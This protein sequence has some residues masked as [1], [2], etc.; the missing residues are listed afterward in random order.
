LKTLAAK[1]SVKTV[2]ANHK[3]APTPHGRSSAIS[4]S[5][6]PFF[7]LPAKHFQAGRYSLIAYSENLA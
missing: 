4:G 3:K 6:P 7:S 2:T 5:E 1:G